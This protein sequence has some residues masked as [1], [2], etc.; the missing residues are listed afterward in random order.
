V[1]RCKSLMVAFSSSLKSTEL[2]SLPVSS[3]NFNFSATPIL[4]SRSPVRP[5]FAF[6]FKS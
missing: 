5:D 1:R 6:D 2:A 3:A 4:R